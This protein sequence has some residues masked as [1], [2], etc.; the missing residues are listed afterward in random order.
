M[1]NARNP[2]GP[3][4]KPAR[5]RQV[6][7]PSDPGLMVLSLE[8]IFKKVEADVSGAP[9]PLPVGR[10]PRLARRTGRVGTV[11]GKSNFDH[12]KLRW[13]KKP[14]PAQTPARLPKSAQARAHRPT[15]EDLACMRG[16]SVPL[17]GASGR[18]MLMAQHSGC[19]CRM[20]V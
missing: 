20:R 8:D 6:G 3:R 16:G 18:G 4:K 12:R 9:S 17:A 13:L 2:H 5:T 19:R 11:A 14:C 10:A 7:L 15:T 1:E